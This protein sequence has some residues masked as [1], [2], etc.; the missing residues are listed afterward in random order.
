MTTNNLPE[1]LDECHELIRRL[2]EE[3]LHLR[4]AGAVF[5]Q[6]AERLNHELRAERSLYA[7]APLHGADTQPSLEAR[8]THS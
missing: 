8:S 7:D 6:L 2:Q 4:A 1:T 3:N 5:G